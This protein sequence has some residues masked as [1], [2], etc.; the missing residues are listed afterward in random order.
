MPGTTDKTDRSRSGPTPT[1]HSPYPGLLLTILHVGIARNL[2]KRLERLADGLS[3]AIFRGKMQPVDLA[4]RLVRQ[5][6]LMVTAE[7]IGPAIPNRFEVT[8]STSDLVEGIDNTLLTSELSH[9]LE[10]TAKERGW[11]TGGPISVELNTDA[12]V[13][14]G[15]IKCAA[16]SV[17]TELPSWGELAEHRGDRHFPLRDN[18]LSIGRSHEADVTIDEAEVSR[19]HAVLFRQAGRLWITDLGSANGTTINGAPVSGEP[20]E[21]GSGDMLSFGPTTFALRVN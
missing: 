16:T 11:R 4:N 7:T 12:A 9:V 15:S 14:R 1:R 5:A 3:A 17:P 19:M 2:E 13:G 8:V 21:V 10:A 18:R 6:D 20:A